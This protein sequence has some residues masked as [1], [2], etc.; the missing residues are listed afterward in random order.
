MDNREE[1]FSAGDA[2]VARRSWCGNGERGGLLLLL[3]RGTSECDDHGNGS[4][5]EMAQKQESTEDKIKE[6]LISG[7]LLYS[8]GCGGGK[9]ENPRG[10]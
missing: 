9:E 1:R 3:P 8:D 5:F 10:R 2:I 7:S 4:Y 6:L